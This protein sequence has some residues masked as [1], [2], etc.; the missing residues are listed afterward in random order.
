MDPQRHVE[1]R[2]SARTQVW[3]CPAA[4]EATPKDTPAGVAD[5]RCWFTAPA[6]AEKKDYAT[7]PATWMS[8]SVL[9]ALCSSGQIR[10]IR[11]VIQ[12]PS[13][14]LEFSSRPGPHQHRRR[15]TTGAA[16]GAADRAG[17]GVQPLSKSRLIPFAICQWRRQAAADS[18]PAV[19]TSTR[20]RTRARI[21]PLS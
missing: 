13:V 7:A 5:V 11:Q 12:V 8:L 2:G 10:D 20:P 1:L 15:S 4:L 6:A 9:D 18:R 3:P 14:F 21:L 17:A 19:N 16:D